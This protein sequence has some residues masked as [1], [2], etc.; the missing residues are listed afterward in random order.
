MPHTGD[1]GRSA[2]RSD[3]FPDSV[4]QVGSVVK[5][6]SR[7]SEVYRRSLGSNMPRRS[8]ARP[9]EVKL[10]CMFAR[11]HQQRSKREE[12]QLCST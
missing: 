2:A 1:A 6:F 3:L 11:H 9:A 4:V 12:V 10:I 5:R 8:H 7:V